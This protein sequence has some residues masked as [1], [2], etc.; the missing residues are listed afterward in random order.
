MRI[1]VI[2]N[3]TSSPKEGEDDSHFLSRAIQAAMNI[4][5]PAMARSFVTKLLKEENVEALQKGEK[6][7]DDLSV[8]VS[9]LTAILLH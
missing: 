9:F 3:P 1:G 6:T 7:L 5:E 2:H 8:H 4:L